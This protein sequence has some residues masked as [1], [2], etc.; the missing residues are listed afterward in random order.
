MLTR[1]W[2]LFEKGGGFFL[3]KANRYSNILSASAQRKH[4]IR[5]LAIVTDNLN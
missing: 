2:S 3:Y 4:L 5:H 1:E